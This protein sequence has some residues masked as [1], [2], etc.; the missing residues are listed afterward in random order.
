MKITKLFVLGFLP[1]CYLSP[2]LC[3]NNSSAEINLRNKNLNALPAEI[4][5]SSIISL[6]VSDNHLTQLS[7][8]LKNASSLESLDLS[9]NK[10]LEAAG[11]CAQLKKLKL[12]NL[13]IDESN[14]LFLPVE[15]SELHSLEYLSLR[16]NYIR[17]LPEDFGAMQSLKELHLEGNSIST[18]PE[19]LALPQSLGF[20]DLDHNPCL[21][22]ANIYK[23]ICRLE[24]LTSLSVKG[25]SYMDAQLFSVQSL[26]TLDMS[27]GTFAAVESLTKVDCQLSS[28]IATGC[29]QL[30]FSTLNPLYKSAT[31]T[32]LEI[33]G[34][35]FNGFQKIELPAHLETLKL[36]GNTLL[37][38]EPS[39]KLAKLK[40][41]EINFNEVQ[42]LDKLVNYL[43][44]GASIKTLSMPF[45]GISVLPHNMGKL[46]GLESLNLQGNKIINVQALYPLKQLLSL[47]VSGCQLDKKQIEKLKENLPS[48]QI[49]N[50]VATP[51]NLAGSEKNRESFTIDVVRPGPIVTS[52]GT[53]I[54]IPP[55]SLVFADGSPVKG[56]VSVTYESYYSLGSIASSGINMNYEENGK[57]V[58]FKSAGMFNLTA[59]ADGKPVELKKGKEMIVSFKSL[60]S[61]QSYNYYSYDPVKQTWTETG[62]DSIQKIRVAKKDTLRR[63][64]S[65]ARAFSAANPMPAKSR[66]IT[67][68]KITMRWRLKGD[69]KGEFYISTESDRKLN[70]DTTC[71]RNY[72]FEIN[73]LSH[74]QWKIEGED[75]KATRK[76]VFDPASKV[77]TS[78]QKKHWWN[79]AKDKRVVETKGATETYLSIEPDK[80]HD[81][82]ILTFYT[83]KDTVRFNAYPDY[84]SHNVQRVQQKTKKLY[85]NFHKQKAIRENITEQRKNRFFRQ[86]QK[87]VTNA[88]II[89]N[90]MW[91]S[92]QKSIGELLAS[93]VNT[94][95]YDVT[96]LLALKG[97]G[98]HNCDHPLPVEQPLF[99]AFKYFSEKGNPL[100]SFSTSFIDVKNN[101]ATNIYKNSRGQVPS[102]TVLT[103]VMTSGNKTYLGKFSTIDY[104]RTRGTAEIKLNE[105]PKNFTIADLDAY[106]TTFN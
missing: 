59:S 82:F 43:E 104:K 12:K 64:D 94:N 81:N 5:Y 34:D 36:S 33:G 61:T 86:Y 10:T 79:S 29:H 90:S 71:A 48:T 6:D 27:D 39:N 87:F 92:Q 40:E 77:F 66:F 100:S 31:L 91:A 75:F 78:Y 19:K 93:K 57:S 63:N 69:H 16:N 1:V 85:D 89:Q 41:V 15:L 35:K 23:A 17:E 102:N 98:I 22:S 38:F 56:P 54:N 76:K 18:I 84:T 20:L 13:T 30:D 44:H 55:N 72:L 62:K 7:S 24:K 50:D 106:I 65:L 49:I 51:L 11:T 95:S 32:E 99:L 53:Q 88:N 42:G 70:K 96:R 47:N 73:E 45:C 26:K 4:D 52:N 21:G 3:Q 9:R 2:A 103:V 14:L 67:H 83:E 101:I 46:T 80:E 28:L 37:Y 68:Q 8:S 58:P 60:D 25:A 74:V 105:A 97:F